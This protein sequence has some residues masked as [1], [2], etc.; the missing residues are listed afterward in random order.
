LLT[1]LSALFGPINQTD[2]EVVTIDMRDMLQPV[3]G[4]GRKRSPTKPASTMEATKLYGTDRVGNRSMT[5]ADRIMF[6]VTRKFPG[7]DAMKLFAEAMDRVA[8]LN[9]VCDVTVM[10]HGQ[11]KGP[12]N[13]IFEVIIY[14]QDNGNHEQ[15][16][17]I[18][19]AWL[20]Q[21]NLKFQLP[22]E[23]LG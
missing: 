3:P 7:V 19:I 2:I 6:N 22:S 12:V 18:L 20:K 9:V 15:A 16:K 8:S 13:R 17:T 5:V 11:D 21:H 1:C 14:R 4:T 10:S 23:V